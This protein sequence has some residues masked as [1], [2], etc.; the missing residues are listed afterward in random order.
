MD[1][2]HRMAIKKLT[3]VNEFVLC[4]GKKRMFTKLPFCKH[5]NITH[6]AQDV[7][8]NTPPDVPKITAFKNS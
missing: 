6:S 4:F 5:I 3:H 2:I 8:N 7:K 1:M